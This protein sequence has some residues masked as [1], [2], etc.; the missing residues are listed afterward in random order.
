MWGN[1]DGDIFRASLATTTQIIEK[2]DMSSVEAGRSPFEQLLH[3]AWATLDV[4][5]ANYLGAYHSHPWTQQEVN[6]ALSAGETEDFFWQ[7]SDG[8]D[9]DEGSMPDNCI[10]IILSL[11]PASTVNPDQ[12]VWQQ[13]GDL[14][15]GRIDIVHITFSGW[16]KNDNGQFSQIAVRGGFLDEVNDKIRNIE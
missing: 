10:E 15:S 8:P 13:R 9:G 1:K 11:R 6:N 14:I 12:Y 7:A 3:N 4:S 2:R 5:D 16:F